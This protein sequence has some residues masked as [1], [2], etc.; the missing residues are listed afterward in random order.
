[1][2]PFEGSKARTVNIPDLV[3][4]EHFFTNEQNEN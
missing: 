1:V 3:A 4:L 2:G